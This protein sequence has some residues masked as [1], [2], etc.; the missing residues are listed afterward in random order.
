[1]RKIIVS[2]DGVVI[3]KVTLVK[4]RTTLGRR[5]YND[6]VLD[7]MAVSGE[8]AVLHMSDSEVSIEDLDSTNGTCV[9]ARPVKKHVLR[10]NDLLEIGKYKIRYLADAPLGGGVSPSR[11]T[12]GTLATMQESHDTQP[13]VAVPLGD[14]ASAAFMRVL[15]GAGAGREVPLNKVVTTIGKPGVAV[16]AVTSRLEGYVVMAVDGGTLL[17]GKALGTEAVPLQN[18]DL[19]ELASTRLQFVHT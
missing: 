10:H 1:M 16:A 3:K 13:T 7:S 12:P 17:N 2:F 4:H 15:S 8:H 9:N 14:I 18:G 11:F 5:P 19:I 6:I